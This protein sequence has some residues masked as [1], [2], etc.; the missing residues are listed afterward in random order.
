[1]KTHTSIHSYV[2]TKERIRF[3]SA[4]LFPFMHEKKPFLR[5]RYSI[6]TLANDIDVP[7]YQL[8]AFIN[9]ELGL[10]FS[11]YLNQFRV[12]YCEQ[13]MHDG[14][15]CQMNLKGLALE[16]GFHNRNTLTNAFKKFT[17]C[18]PSSYQKKEQFHIINKLSS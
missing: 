18:T 3:I 8:S 16:C 5:F 17:G 2:L 6:H 13:L 7:A 14:L 11:D 9:R 1:M 10:N 15:V 12:R 4:Q